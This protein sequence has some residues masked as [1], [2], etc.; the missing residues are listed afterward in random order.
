MFKHTKKQILK[1]CDDD[2]IYRHIEPSQAKPAYTNIYIYT[3]K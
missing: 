3:K 2:E 1:L